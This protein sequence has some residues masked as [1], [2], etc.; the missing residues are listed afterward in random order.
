MDDVERLV[1][2][3]REEMVILFTDANN[4]PVNGIIGLAGMFRNVR[5]A[6]L[7]IETK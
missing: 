3:S 7:P 4:F 2:F 6:Y 5:F 1:Y